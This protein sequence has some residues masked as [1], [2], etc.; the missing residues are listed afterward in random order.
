M[1][2]AVFAFFQIAVAQSWIPNG[3]SLL[4]SLQAYV[5]D[6]WFL[7]VAFCIFLEALVF[8]CFYFPGQ[9]IAALLII[10]NDP[11]MSDIVLLTIAMLIATTAGSFVNYVWGYSSSRARPEN[12]KLQYRTLLPALVHSSGLAFFTFN[13]GLR[14]GSVK[15]IGMAALFNLPYYFLILI[16]T[17]TFGDAILANSDN[18][19]IVGGALMIWLG[20]SAFRDWKRNNR[21]SSQLKLQRIDVISQL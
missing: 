2:L 4:Q 1:A 6:H 15:L 8:V 20:I 21:P 17:T 14:Q 18:W 13:W 5:G 9:Y 19:L 11:E 10:V 12:P 7:F 3:E 16:V